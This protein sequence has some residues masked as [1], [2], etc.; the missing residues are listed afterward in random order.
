[1]SDTWIWK[2]WWVVM[3]CG[4]VITLALLPIVLPFR[5]WAAA[6]TA[7]F[8]GPEGFA[9]WNGRRRFPDPLERYKAPYPPLTYVA[10][11]YLPRWLTYTA[12]GGLVGT[13]SAM[14]FSMPKPLGVGGTLALFSWLVEH[15]EVTYRE[16]PKPK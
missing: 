14:W 16:M 15:W 12:T 1:M 9:I 10:R 4:I 7:G 11:Y 8:G 13:I 5:E 6:A 3:W 2:K